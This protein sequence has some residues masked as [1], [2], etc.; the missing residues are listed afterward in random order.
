MQENGCFRLSSSLG[1]VAILNWSYCLL[2]L[3]LLG[4]SPSQKNR[5]GEIRNVV[6]GIIEAD[7]QGDLD[8]VLKHYHDDAV[9]APPGKPEISGLANIRKNYEDIFDA[10]RMELRIEIQEIELAGETAICRGRT[11]GKVISK[12][13]S[14]AI[15]VDDKIF[16][17]T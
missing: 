2:F 1:L 5:T 15:D 4:C 10:S 6:T 8:Q 9:L 14:S 16:D 3:F 12:S 17:D 13:D 7:N 11:L